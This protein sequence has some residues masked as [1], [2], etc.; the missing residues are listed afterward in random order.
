[1]PLFPDFEILVFCTFLKNFL[2]SYVI[3]PTE[4]EMTDQIGDKSTS[5]VGILRTLVEFR[6]ATSKRFRIML[7]CILV[8]LMIRYYVLIPQLVLKMLVRKTNF[9]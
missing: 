8:T 7:P 6:L 3:K 1:M 4:K 5:S 2:F 9:N